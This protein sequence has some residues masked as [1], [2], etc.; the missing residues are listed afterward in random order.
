MKLKIV[1]PERVLMEKEV[2]SISVTTQSG[3]ITI[4]NNHVPMVSNLRA[5]ELRYVEKGEMQFFALSRG[6]V[7]VRENNQVIILAD[8]AEF[9]HEIDIDRAEKARET[10]KAMM[11]ENYQDD[12]ASADAVA[13]LEKNLARLKV[14]R[15]HRTHTNRNLESG[16]MHE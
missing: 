1:T 2:E 16:I 11:Q 15:K 14:A 13:L 5:G 9:G 4:L 3:E 8:T 12:K 6:F 7:E 10:A